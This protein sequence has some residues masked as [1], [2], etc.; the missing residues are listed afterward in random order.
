MSMKLFVRFAVVSRTEKSIGSSS[1]GG[2]G[3][4]TGTG[5]LGHFGSSGSYQSLASG[6]V[7]P[8]SSSIVSLGAALIPGITHIRYSTSSFEHNSS[9]FT[10]C[11]LSHA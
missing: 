9:L 7:G 1:Q 2:T 10:D 11:S 4:G 5:T 8:S 3:A 6:N